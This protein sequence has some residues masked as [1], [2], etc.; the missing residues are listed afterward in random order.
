MKQP[1]FLGAVSDLLVDIS[2]GCKIEIG[3]IF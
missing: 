1:R 3:D 2:R